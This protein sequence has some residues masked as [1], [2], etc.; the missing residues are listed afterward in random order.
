LPR[1]DGWD[2]A[3]SDD[4]ERI[5]AMRYSGTVEGNISVVANWPRAVKR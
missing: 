4:G 1:P 2:Y 3:V 5:L